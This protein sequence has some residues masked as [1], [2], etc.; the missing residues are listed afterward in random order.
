MP[1]TIKEMAFLQTRFSSLTLRLTPGCLFY[2][3]CPLF[4][5]EEYLCILKDADP[6]SII[7]QAHVRVL[8][9]WTKLLSVSADFLTGRRRTRGLRSFPSFP[10]AAVASGTIMTRL[11]FATI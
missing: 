1:F 9:S 3:P 10:A 2:F 7:L 5:F 8:R 6:L 4:C 11:V